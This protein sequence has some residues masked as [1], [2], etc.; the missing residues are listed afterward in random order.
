MGDLSEHFS[1]WEFECQGAACCGGSS[2]ID[3]RL[4]EA[5]EELRELAGGRAL[6]INSGFRCRAYN[7]TI[8]N[9]SPR[10]QHCLGRA[11]DVVVPAG[12]TL[13]AFADLAAEVPDFYFG[14]IGVYPGRGFV[15]VD[16]RAGDPKV[17]TA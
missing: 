11:A 15:H 8:E 2:P 16:V 10:S 9:S 5:L 4:V 7:A 17:W 1:A 6:S 13:E 12:F 3:S 14:G